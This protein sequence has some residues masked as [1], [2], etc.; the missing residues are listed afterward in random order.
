MRLKYTYT[1]IFAL[2]IFLFGATW[3]LY[4][5]HSPL[6]WAPSG[7]L[8]ILVKASPGDK[9][10]LE[11]GFGIDDM[12]LYTNEGKTIRVTLRTRRVLLNPST[13]SLTLLLQ[14]D[15]P[16]GNYTAFAFVMKSPE[17]RN[18]WEDN[19]PAK[20]VVLAGDRVVMDVRYD[21]EENTSTAIVLSFDTKQ[22]LHAV[23][24]KL[25]YTPVLQVE[26]RKNTTVTQDG[27]NITVVDGGEIGGIATY[28]MDWNGIMRFN[29]REKTSTHPNQ[30]PPVPTDSLDTASAPE[31]KNAYVIPESTTLDAP[32]TATTTPEEILTPR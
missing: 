21:V 9:E 26:T 11:L 10:G 16:I 31:E 1:L 19:T 18:A 2:F 25:I 15:V 14:T 23:N 7:Q 24:D 6:P 5:G 12:I 13:N 22:A 30:I 20:Q 27:N 4:T 17:L 29:F 32:S 3:W 8:T 28:G